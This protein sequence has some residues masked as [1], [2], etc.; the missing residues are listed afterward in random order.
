MALRLLVMNHRDHLVG[1]PVPKAA[2]L[3]S[4]VMDEGHV[5]GRFVDHDRG[6]M[7]AVVEQGEGAGLV[8]VEFAQRVR[9]EVAADKAAYVAGGKPDLGFEPEGVQGAVVAG[10]DD[11]G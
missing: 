3:R 4:E 11:G 6:L 7:N 8:G 2:V 5:D 10:E 9:F 1:K